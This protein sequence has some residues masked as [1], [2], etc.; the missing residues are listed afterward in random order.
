MKQHRRIPEFRAVGLPSQWALIIITFPGEPK[1]RFSN[2][3]RTFLLMAHLWWCSYRTGLFKNQ[4]TKTS[5]ILLYRRFNYKDWFFVLTAW[6]QATSLCW[7]YLTI[8]LDTVIQQPWGLVIIMVRELL[9]V[10]GHCPLLD[11][12]MPSSSSS[13]ALKVLTGNIRGSLR[14]FLPGANCY[15]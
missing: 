11:P 15:P 13:F 12:C 5:D 1:F 14:G 3:S 4:L 8:L 7:R 2:Y 9:P 10:Q 6:Y